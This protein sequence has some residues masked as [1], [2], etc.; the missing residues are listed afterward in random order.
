MVRRKAC[1]HR[2]AMATE[3]IGRVGG[4]CALHQPITLMAHRRTGLPRMN[5]KQEK[6]KPRRVDQ[7]K[8]HN[9]RGSY[10][11]IIVFHNRRCI[12]RSTIAPPW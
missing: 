6:Q 10:P 2:G 8:A 12:N 1:C 4:M 7:R 5:T 3:A 9:W 11:I